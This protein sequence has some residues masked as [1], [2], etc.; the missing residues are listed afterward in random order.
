[1][2]ASSGSAPLPIDPVATYH[3]R[4]VTPYLERVREKGITDVVQYS[5]GIQRGSR[6][7]LLQMCGIHVPKE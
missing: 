6:W 4:N 3:G 1:M 2:L 5:P 7:S